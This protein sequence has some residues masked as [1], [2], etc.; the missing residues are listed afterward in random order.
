MLD[1][2][3]KEGCKHGKNLL[4][5]DDCGHGAQE[6][7]VAAQESEEFCGGSQD[8]PGHE[9]PTADDRGEQLAAA[10]VDVLGAEGDE[11]VCGADGVCRDVDAQRDDDQADCAKSRGRAAGVRSRV[12]PEADDHDRVPLHL[13]VGRLRCCGGEDAEE[14]DEGW[15]CVLVGCWQSARGQCILKMTGMTKAWMFCELGFFE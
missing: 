13:A 14:T 15:G 8:L 6:N 11:V 12:G 2:G 3:R 7:R 4:G 5:H 10:D 9:G 1:V